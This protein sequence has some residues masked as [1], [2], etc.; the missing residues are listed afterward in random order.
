VGGSAQEWRTS[1]EQGL[2]AGSPVERGLVMT[3]VSGEN[4]TIAYEVVI[5]TG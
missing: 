1:I 2:V 5:Q 3:N 4:V